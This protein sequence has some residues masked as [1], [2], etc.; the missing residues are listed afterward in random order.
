MRQTIQQQRA[1]FAHKVVVQ[2]AGTVNPPPS[3]FR[4]LARSL[5][6]MISANGLGQTLAM[7]TAADATAMLSAITDWL[8]LRNHPHGLDTLTQGGQEQ[9]FIAQAEAL[10][11]AEWIKVIATALIAPPQLAAM[12]VSALPDFVT[13]TSAPEGKEE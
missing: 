1:A 10:K 13:E 8:K 2:V 3:K 12:Q 4:S 9:Y 11:I 5:P 7:L 6:M